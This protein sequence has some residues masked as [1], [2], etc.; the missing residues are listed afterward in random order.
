MIYKK[1]QHR[2]LADLRWYCLARKFSILWQKSTFGCHLRRIKSFY[3]EKLLRQHFLLWKETIDEEKNEEQ[4]TEYYHQQ[5]LRHTLHN[6][7]TVT[8]QQ[9]QESH[10]ALEHLHRKRLQTTWQLW[11]TQFAKRRLR[12]RQFNMANEQYHR[13]VLVRV[14]FVR[15]LGGR[16]ST[17][18]SFISKF[19][20]LW[21]TNTSQRQH[22]REKNLRASYHRR[23]HMQR[24]CFQAWVTYTEY[25]RR[26]NTH[27]SK[28]NERENHVLSLPSERVQD[29][30]QRRLVGRIYAQWKEA[31]TS[32]LLIQQHEHRLAQLRERVLLR[33]A[34][35]RWKYCSYRW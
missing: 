1:A 6:W 5:L 15:F 17:V 24:I 8:V 2:S 12:Q 31:L 21:Q 30:Y 35:E 9:R 25:R 28:V 4:A 20:H 19:Y 7:W 10:L 23:I 14:S 16:L 11:K 33:W 29:Y 3:H 22:E 27:K 26:K 13:T 32:Q 34:W 18:E